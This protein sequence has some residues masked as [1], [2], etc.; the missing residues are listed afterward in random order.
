MTQEGFDTLATARNALIVES[1]ASGD[2]HPNIDAP[3]PAPELIVN[4]IMNDIKME[5]ADTS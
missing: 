1:S 2:N 5:S 3:I 4:S